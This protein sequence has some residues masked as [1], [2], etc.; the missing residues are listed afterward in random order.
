MFKRI[1]LFMILNIA[2]LAVLAIAANLLGLTGA[3]GRELD[4]MKLLG[5]AALLGFGGAFISLLL[6]KPMAKWTTKA[7]PV[8]TNNE[9]GAWLYSTVER[10]A[11]AMNIKT[12]EV[13]IYN[14][15]EPNAFAT[16]ATKNSS[17]VAVS[18][19]LL[20]KLSR[21]EVE[22][23]LGHEVGHAA[24]GDMVTMALLQG[25]LNT[26]V[27]FVARIIGWVVDRVV[28]KNEQEGPG[29]A[30]IAVTIVLE[31]ALGILASIILAW[32]SRKREFVADAAGAHLTSKRAM[33]NALRRLDINSPNAGLPASMAAMGMRGNHSLMKLFSTHPS[34]SERVKALEET[35]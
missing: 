1:S 15:Q 7:R 8:D 28:L 6:S 9:V 11:M 14:A 19:G 20:E 4:L 35:T 13:Y 32:Y 26:F 22:A 30:Q 23:V 12:P 10:Q 34:M 5:F 2:V 3:T 21:E 18:T 31:I 24:N 33:A 16:G 27:I 25:V 29:I 17:M